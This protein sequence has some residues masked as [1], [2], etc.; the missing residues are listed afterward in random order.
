LEIKECMVE[1]ASSGITSIP[2]FD[3]EVGRGN[4]HA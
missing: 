1:M 2:K 4:I 3:L